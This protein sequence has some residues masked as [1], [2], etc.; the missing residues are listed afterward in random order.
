MS[1]RNSYE[2]GYRYAVVYS[3]KG[4][5]G[6]SLANRANVTPSMISKWRSLYSDDPRAE[7]IALE[8]IR[9]SGNDDFAG[10]DD[11]TENVD[12]PAP[13]NHAVESA[14]AGDDS[15]EEPSEEPDRKG[16]TS[17]RFGDRR[18][19]ARFSSIHGIKK[20]EIMFNVTREQVIQYKREAKAW[21]EE[22]ATCVRRPRA[23]VR[24]REEE[25]APQPSERG[26]EE[27]DEEHEEESD[28]SENGEEES[29]EESDEERDEDMRI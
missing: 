6:V 14:D 24:P 12:S 19:I 26:H 23:T 10:N 3:G 2:L 11:S 22:K 7:S 9:A 4:E 1:R 15:Q 21:L 5:S 20:A 27:E 25:T 18:V 28:E 16:L 13:S 8:Y 29:D 17:Y